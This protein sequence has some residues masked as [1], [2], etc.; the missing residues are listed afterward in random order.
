MA[1]TS[2]DIYGLD[3]AKERFSKEKL[4]NVMAKEIGLATLKLHGVLKTAVF[5]RYTANNDLEKQLVR[6]SSIVSFG[7]GIIEGS[8]IY[9]VKAADLSKFPTTWYWGNI[10]P[11]ARVRGRVHTVTIIRGSQKVSHGKDHRGGFQ[12]RNKKGAV[13]RIFRGGSQMLERTSNSKFPLRV[14]YGPN[15]KNMIS[16]VLNN[17][18]NVDKVMDNLVLTIIDNYI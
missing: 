1:T 18:P 9:R 3:E 14:L 7:K 8:L 4:N 6:R 5:N 12:P 11:G 15:T 17:D 2:I 13:S 16:W 10:N